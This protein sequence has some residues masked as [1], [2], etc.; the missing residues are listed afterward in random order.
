[1]RLIKRYSNRKL[2][3]TATRTY[4]TLDGIAALV[5][6]GAEIKVVDNDTEEDLTTVILSQLLLERERAR[7]SLSSGLLSGLLRSGENIG[8]NLSSLTRPLPLNSGGLVAMLEHEIERS[9]KFWLELGKGSEEEVLRAIEGVIEKRRKAQI[10]EPV[11]KAKR[12][13]APGLGILRRRS[14]DDFEDWNEENEP[15]TGPKPVKAARKNQA[16]RIPITI[17]SDS[18]DEHNDHQEE[19]EA[20]GLRAR[21]LLK[22]LAEIRDKLEGLEADQV[23]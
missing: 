18:D 13:P 11:P 12:L 21:Q 23:Q 10:S 15:E 20:L 4:I 6:D 3:D 8:R 16:S 22:E 19:I 17:A 9:L 1:M 14:L 5:Q 2:Y 7:R